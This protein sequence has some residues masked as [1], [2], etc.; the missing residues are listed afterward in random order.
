MVRYTYDFLKK[1]KLNFLFFLLFFLVIT[2]RLI[3][4][5]SYK[6][7]LSKGEANNIWNA[8]SVASGK[9]MYSNPEN[10]PFEILQYTPYSQ[11]PIILFTKLFNKEYTNYYY[12]IV[13]GRVL[14]LIYNL[15]TFVFL[16]KLMN[17]TL[18]IHFLIAKWASFLGFCTLTH[19][20]FSIRPDAMGLL[21]T[22]LSLYF[23]SKSYFNTNNK[24]LVLSSVL[25]SIC[26]Y[27]KQ[28]AFLIILIL[29]LILL[30]MKELKSFLIFTISFCLVFI[31]LSVINRII[32]GEFFF[33]SILGGVNNGISI[34]RAIDVFE[35]YITFYGF[36]FFIG[37]FCCFYVTKI[38][39]G[40]K[41]RLYLVSLFAFSILLAF[42]SSL[43]N[44]SWINYYTLVNIC[45]IVVIS[46]L[47]NYVH[48]YGRKKEIIFS[49]KSITTIFI[50]YFLYQQIYHYTSPFM[51]YFESKKYHEN[52]THQFHSLKMSISNKEI[53]IYTS[54]PDLKLYFFKNI[55]FPNYEFYPVSSFSKKSYNNLPN[56]QQISL[57]IL[58][59]PYLYYLN[60]SPFKEFKID[61]TKFK[62]VNN[63]SNFVVL[64]NGNNKI[65]RN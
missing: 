7:E 32:F 8:L 34:R 42:L 24:W 37:L 6:L 65:L 14:S 55:I 38:N 17:S 56:N 52:L 11:L 36:L 41:Y 59:Q 40:L 9:M 50:L 48:I 53:P 1:N 15:L 63:N 51:K 2:Y 33:Y 22:I 12:I 62:V 4:C 61:K 58:D 26:F 44:G 28:D 45:S 3:L 20:S 21:F 27:I 64:E 25:F 30:I 35:R 43:K 10:S 23:Y 5:F 57:I 49:L 16:Y 46:F 29:G 54:N 18:K 39:Q 13:F 60:G 31:I 19:L 47:V